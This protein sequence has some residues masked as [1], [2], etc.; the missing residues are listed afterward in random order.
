MIMSKGRMT[1]NMVH[2][3]ELLEKLSEQ[4]REIF[5]YSEQPI[6]LYLDDNHW[7]CN[8]KF[9]DLL[10]YDSPHEAVGI[11]EPFLDVFVDGMSQASLA[12]AYRNAM[13]RKVGST[14]EVRWRKKAG[15][16]VNADVMLV[17][18]AYNGHIFALHFLS[19][20]S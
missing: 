17:P 16:T 10:G 8:K 5:E 9:S 7:A 20:K 18:I 3:E 4:L 15:G 19:A 6:Y 13:E 14:I 11:K 1:T 12:T 2:H